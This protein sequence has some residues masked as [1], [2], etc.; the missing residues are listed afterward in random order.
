[1]VLYDK[2][3]DLRMDN[4]LSQ[5]DHTTN[6]FIVDLPNFYPPQPINPFPLKIFYA[7]RDWVA[8]AI[9]LMLKKKRIVESQVTAL[10][11]AVAKGIFYAA[12]TTKVLNSSYGALSQN[13]PGAKLNENVQALVNVSDVDK[14]IYHS[15]RLLKL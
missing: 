9:G 3:A 11:E 5:L 4:M 12:L 14:L 2:N 15:M 8:D 6:P 7:V 1:M 13:I 10:S